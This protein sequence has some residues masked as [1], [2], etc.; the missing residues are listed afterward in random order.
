MRKKD[1]S[2][3]NIASKLDVPLPQK[4]ENVRRGEEI[5]LEID[6][7]KCE[8][9][10]IQTKQEKVNYYFRLFFIPGMAG[11]SMGWMVFI[12]FILCASSFSWC[13]WMKCSISDSFLIALISGCSVNIIGLL[14]IVLAYLFP[15]AHKQD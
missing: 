3:F 1:L 13:K 6:A 5:Q 9:E 14:T 2:V 11:I 10:K 15:K 7:E 12:G 8:Q 4:D